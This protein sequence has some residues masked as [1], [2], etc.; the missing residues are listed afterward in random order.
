MPY[1]IQVCTNSR[2][3]AF[4]WKWTQRSV[5]LL[6]PLLLLLLLLLLVL[7]L[8]FPPVMPDS[9]EP[10]LPAET[11]LAVCATLGV[12]LLVTPRI[13]EMIRC[14]LETEYFFIR[15]QRKLKQLRLLQ[16]SLESDSKFYT[17]CSTISGNLFLRAMI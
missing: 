13:S 3:P 6:L 15:E 14:S 8:T 11:Y 9:S 1:T 10:L 5:L 17:G 4:C 16:A 12:N 2:R 7:L